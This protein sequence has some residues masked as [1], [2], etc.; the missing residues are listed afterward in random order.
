MSAEDFG[1]DGLSLVVG[2]D[3]LIA[4]IGTDEEMAD[5]Y[6]SAKADTEIDARNK[7]VIPGFVDAHTHPVWAGDRVHEFAMKLAGASYMEV[8]AAGG[9]I[10]F[11]VNHTR[12]A[13]EDELFNS[14]K[15]RL[16]QMLANGTTLVE[17]K[18]GYGLDVETELKMLR[19]IERA[20][21]ELPIGISATFCGAHSI[22]KGIS[23][24]SAADNVINE[25]L[26]AVCQL[27]ESGDLSVDSIDVFFEKGVFGPQTTRRILEAGKQAGLALNFHGD[28]LSPM[29]AGK[30]AGEMSARAVSHLEEVSCDGIRAMAKAGTVAV[31]L[32]TT[33]YILR[34]KQPPA[35]K[36]IEEGLH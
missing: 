1:A 26:P 36:M 20:K 7:S 21:R 2:A 16:L 13:T 18:S 24:E 5:K 14:L 32:P 12:H 31:L 11:T 6:G 27:M 28:E 10:Q 4:D 19:V 9:G 3:G 35:R 15:T 22:P 33:A 25:Q 29:E 17:C 30:L 23:E 34:L 8:H